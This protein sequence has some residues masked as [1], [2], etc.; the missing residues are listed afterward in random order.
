MLLLFPVPL[1]DLLLLT[2]ILFT[3]LGASRVRLKLWDSPTPEFNTKASSTVF[4][5][6]VLVVSNLAH[7]IVI[8]HDFMRNFGMEPRY[9]SGVP[10]RFEGSPSSFSAPLVHPCFGTIPS[11][12]TVATVQAR[13][14][15]VAESNKGMIGSGPVEVPKRVSVAVQTTPDEESQGSADV[16]VSV[17]MDEGKGAKSSYRVPVGIWDIAV[18][19]LDHHAGKPV[20][21]ALLPGDDSPHSD[22]SPSHGENPS[23]SPP[24]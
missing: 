21:G 17:L 22:S 15:V 4:E 9:S 10:L 11:L 18:S 23:S 3:V 12:G 1:W 2:R 6:V 5:I 13:D 20:L 8:G 24:R 7:K 19:D 16:S 14:R